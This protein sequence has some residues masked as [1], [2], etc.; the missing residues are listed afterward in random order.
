MNVHFSAMTL[1][2]ELEMDNKNLQRHSAKKGILDTKKL[3]YQLH[4]VKNI[5][6][7]MMIILKEIQ[8]G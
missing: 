8:M 6:S 3:D 5:I 7:V 1:E 4:M 2:L